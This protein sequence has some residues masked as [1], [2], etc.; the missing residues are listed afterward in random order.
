MCLKCWSKGRKWLRKSDV[1]RK[2]VPE[3]LRGVRKR[4]FTVSL[5]VDRW[6][7][8]Y[9]DVCR[10]LELQRWCVNLAQIWKTDRTSRSDSTRT[11]FVFDSSID[12]KPVQSVKM[13]CIVWSVLWAFKMRRLHC[14][15]PPEVCSEGTGG[16]GKEGIS[17][18]QLYI[19]P[20]RWLD[21]CSAVDT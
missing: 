12:W 13:R 20:L 2:C 11:K 3:C 10:R 1:F 17:M 7:A 18:V 19:N 4:V 16:T 21:L 8:Q 6:N 14:S 9:T 5:S 15:E